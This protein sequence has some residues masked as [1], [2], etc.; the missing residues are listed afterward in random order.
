[1]NQK[2]FDPEE[3]AMDI[4]ATQEVSAAGGLAAALAGGLINEEVN[5]QNEATNASD[6]FKDKG[7]GVLKP[8][9]PEGETD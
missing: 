1:M 5:E 7:Q 8:P 2:F 4:V 3:D 9:A 6:A